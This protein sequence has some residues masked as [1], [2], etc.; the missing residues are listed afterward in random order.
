[1]SVFSQLFSNIFKSRKNAKK[2]ASASGQ[3]LVSQINRSV[4]QLLQKADSLNESWENERNILK[5][6]ANEV[7]NFV[8]E[9]D[10]LSAK[11]EQDILGKITACSSAC[12]RVIAGKQSTDFVPL[13]QSLQASVKQ[14]AAMTG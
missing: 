14:R 3:T 5:E 8:P 1:M 10:I 2:T 9:N 6:I 13:L 7:K 4:G 12:D 11:F